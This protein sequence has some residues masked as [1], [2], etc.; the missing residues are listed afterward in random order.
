M[1][2]RT[3]D[4]AQERAEGM[5]LVGGGV[6]GGGTSTWQA[7]RAT[8]APGNRSTEDGERKFLRSKMKLIDTGCV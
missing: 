5:P 1:G 6:A 8:R 3:W 2:L 7:C 4:P